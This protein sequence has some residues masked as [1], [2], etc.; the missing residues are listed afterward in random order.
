MTNT[1]SDTT[2][3]PENKNSGSDSTQSSELPPNPLD[4]LVEE[5][6]GVGEVIKK[7]PEVERILREHPE[8]AGALLQV[9]T[10]THF[11]G[12]LPPP[13]IMKGYEDICPGA[14]RDILDMAKNDAEHIRQMQKGALRGN[15]IETVLGII[16]GLII[17][18]SA[19]GAITYAAV[20]GQPVTAGVVGSV[21]VLAGVFMRKKVTRPKVS[22]IE[23]NDSS[24]E[25]K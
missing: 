13:D 15:T 16:S 7:T 22:K 21:A 23:E 11:S 5:E 6:P 12:P 14:A 9:T 10:Q 2:P 25:T 18:L 20:S 24:Q 19:I 3:E 4:V 17:S 8:V 1:K